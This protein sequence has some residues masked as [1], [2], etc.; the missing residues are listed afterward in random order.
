MRMLISIVMIAAGSSV[1]HA[2]WAHSM[3]EDPFQGDA[4]VAVAVE[5]GSGYAAGFRCIVGQD[6]EL[7]FIFMTPEKMEDVRALSAM[8]IKL[9]V[10]VDDQPKVELEGTADTVGDADHLRIYSKDPAVSGLIKAALDAKRRLAVAAEMVGQIFH[11]HTFS[12]RGSTR[13]ISEFTSGCKLPL[14]PQAPSAAT[15]ER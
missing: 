5:P 7:S 12:M 2:D 10:I 9:L 8:P 13:A 3:T 11:S 1:V 15:P 6:A 4:H 14:Q